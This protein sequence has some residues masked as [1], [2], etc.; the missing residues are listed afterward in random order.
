MTTKIHDKLW[1]VKR[2]NDLA[3][4]TYYEANKAFEK[5]KRTGMN[6]AGKWY[7]VPQDDGTYAKKYKEHSA[8]EIVD[9]VPLS[10]FEIVKG[11]SRWSTQNKV[12]QVR[13]PRGFEVQ[14][15]S[16]NLVELVRHSTIKDGIV[17]SECIWGKD[18]SNHILLTVNSE[19]YLEV[20]AKMEK[21]ANPVKPQDLTPGDVVTEDSWHSSTLQFLGRGRLTWENTR[22]K[23]TV[24]DSW[25][26]LW[27]NDD[28]IV[29]Y[30]VNIEKVVENKP[31]EYDISE[32]RETSY[33]IPKRV[34]NKFEKGISH[35]VPLPRSSWY[36]NRTREEGDVF[37]IV[38]VEMK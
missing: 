33:V 30:K 37:R 27:F 17:Q 9:N 35:Q 28:I 26:W 22:T 11:V 23:E 34:L 3:Y 19:P 32:F 36:G 2:A 20:L 7:Y 4:M 15:P 21:L 14:I 12:V 5:R 25:Q 10:G 8:G 38:E 16:G 18:N 29:T 24:R 6:W 1:F 13:D 31:V